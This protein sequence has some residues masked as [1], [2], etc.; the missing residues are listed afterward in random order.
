M[1]IISGESPG[2]LVRKGRRYCCFNPHVADRKLSFREAKCCALGHQGER[3]VYLL[4]IIIKPTTSL[5]ESRACSIQICPCPAAY[6]LYSGVLV[7][8]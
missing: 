5:L 7:N 3:E 1:C 8:A 4:C 2:H 6:V